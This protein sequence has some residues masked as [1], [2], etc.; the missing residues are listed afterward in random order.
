MAPRVVLVEAALIYVDNRDVPALAA[1]DSR[2]EPVVCGQ[3]P[4]ATIVA[5]AD[6]GAYVG[7]LEPWKVL[8]AEESCIPH[9]KLIE[10][11]EPRVNLK[12]SDERVALFTP[13]ARN[14]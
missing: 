5:I 2:A 9:I 13:S 6:V 12:L 10:I 1:Y 14:Y 8:R 3:V 7:N 11:E 4:L